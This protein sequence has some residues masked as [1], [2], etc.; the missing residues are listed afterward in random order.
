VYTRMWWPYFFIFLLF[1]ITVRWTNQT[2][3]YLPR[4]QEPTTELG[5]DHLFFF[6]G[7]IWFG[8]SEGELVISLFL[9]LGSFFVET[10]WWRSSFEYFVRRVGTFNWNISVKCCLK[11]LPKIFQVCVLS[12]EEINL[13]SNKS[14]EEK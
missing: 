11:Y 12:L 3:C 1:F 8:F 2:W 14:C 9:S 13:N 10:I 5:V 4:N 6:W 7:G